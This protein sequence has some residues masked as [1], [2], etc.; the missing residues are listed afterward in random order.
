MRTRPLMRDLLPQDDTV[1]RTPAG[2][3]SEVLSSSCRVT[4]RREEYPPRGQCPQGAL[5]LR[6]STGIVFLSV[7]REKLS[8]SSWCVLSVDGFSIHG[9]QSYIDDVILSLFQERD[10]RVRPNPDNREGE[11]EYFYYEY[12]ISAQAMRE[13]LD[14]LGF[15]AERARADYA[16]GHAEQVEIADAEELLLEANREGLRR[17]T[18]DY[19]RA[20]IGR[21]VPHGFHTWDW[22]KWSHDLTLRLFG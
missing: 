2:H 15:T 13:R 3:R 10:R 9:S 16:R 7:K 5:T 20:A 22:G 8:M 11:Q 12:A 6:V 4:Q 1:R 18:Y 17:R 21:L 19:W 14:T